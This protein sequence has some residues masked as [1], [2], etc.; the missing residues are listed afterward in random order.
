MADFTISDVLA[1]ARTKPADERYN[2]IDAANCALGCFLRETRNVSEIDLY[3]N[4]PY[5]AEIEHSPLGR[6]LIG[7]RTYG[8]LVELLERSVPETRWA[9]IDAYLADIEHAD[10]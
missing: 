5:F 3:A 8:E 6:A 1:W 9:A 4:D 2:F 7:A 10:A